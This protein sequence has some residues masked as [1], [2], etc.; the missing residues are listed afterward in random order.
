[1]FLVGLGGGY[2]LFASK[3]TS[4]NTV[5]NQQAKI[6]PTV[7]QESPSPTNSSSQWKTYKTENYTIDYPTDW[8]TYS[9]PESP[10]C[11]GLSDIPNPQ[12]IPG[13]IDPAGH[14]LI[15]ICDSNLAMPESF[16]YTNGSSKNI[17]IKPFSIS[18]YSG[19]RGKQTSTLGEVDTVYLNNPGW[20]HIEMLLELGDA[21][22]FQ[23][24]LSTF[25]F[26]HKFSE[27]NP[28]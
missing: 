5:T 22:I 26:T 2:M 24:I 18:E 7:I 9:Y 12:D 17:T 6:S 1:M 19:I 20:G 25:K 27:K 28:Q 23:Q 3:S 10:S 21:N 13:K 4:N 15:Q 8:S 11:V 16:P 14:Q